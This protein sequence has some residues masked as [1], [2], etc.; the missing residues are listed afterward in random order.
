MADL[1]RAANA[2]RVADD[3]LAPYF[4]QCYGDVPFAARPATVFN[5]QNNMLPPTYTINR[6]N[7]LVNSL[8]MTQDYKLQFIIKPRAI[9]QGNW[10]NII[11]FSSNDSDWGVFGSR[12][13][14]IWFFPSELKLH[15]RIGAYNDLNWG[16][17]IPGCQI[18]KE[19]MFSLECRG[20]SVK[21]TL[22]GNVHSVTHPNWRYS[23]NVKVYGSNPW[24]TPALADIKDVGLQLFGNSI[25]VETGPWRVNVGNS[26]AHE[27]SVPLPPGVSSTARNIRIISQGHSDDFVCRIDGNNLIVR[28]VDN[29]SG[30]GASYTAEISE[31]DMPHI[32]NIGFVRV[33]GGSVLNMSQLV[34]LDEKGNNIS[35]GRAQQASSETY[36]DAN[37][38]KAND[39]DERPRGHPS[40]YHGRGA[41]DLWQ[42][43]LNGLSKVSAVI[44][45]NRSDCCSD[46]MASG[47]VIK[48]YA[49]DGAGGWKAVFVSNK[50]T[51]SQVQVVR[52]VDNNTGWKTVHGNNGTVTCQQ[53]CSGPRSIGA[54][55]GP[56][57][58]ELPTEWNGAKCVRSSNP[59]LGCDRGPGRVVSGFTCVCEKT[60][61]GW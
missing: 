53:Y 39:G 58:G 46:R 44:V 55:P 35:R 38:T 61:K 41:D 28:R 10:G 31:G 25:K 20:T 49:P 19:S 50:L 47:F 7:V 29:H 9:V 11:H 15:V 37:K 8:T 26:G 3:Q 43:Q 4:R 60:G 48:L 56:W 30:W 1:H 33:E 16:I 42:V 24:Y 23:G 27:K 59:D 36:G 14:A 12:T 54:A 51:A 52:T 18:N 57:N 45:Y 6:G 21:I 5:I 22:D 13:P 40:Q 32:G 2:Q 17:D 34:V